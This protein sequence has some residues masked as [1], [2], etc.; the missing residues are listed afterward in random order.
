MITQ[1]F[2]PLGW[3]VGIAIAAC[4]LYLVSLQ[5]ASERGRLEEIDRVIASTQRDIRNLQTELGTRASLRQLER[6][7]GEVLALTSPSASQFLSSEDALAQLDPSELES[8]VSAPPA[9]MIPVLMAKKDQTDDQSPTLLARLAAPAVPVKAF[10][11]ADR[12]VQKALLQGQ[13]EPKPVRKSAQVAM[14]DS[15]II[16][17]LTAAAASETRGRNAPKR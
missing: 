9:M 12:A 14:L 13:G 4:G 10:T 5:V 17:D 1:R 16:G 7:N 11:G 2:R 15:S 8:G 6:W 3:V